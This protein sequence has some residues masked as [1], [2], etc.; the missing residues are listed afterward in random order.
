MFDEEGN[1]VS[2]ELLEE[3]KHLQD[4]ISTQGYQLLIPFKIYDSEEFK[5]RGE[6]I[7]EGSDTAFD[8]LD[9]ALSTLAL[10][11]R[12]NKPFT[13]APAQFDKNGNVVEHNDLDTDITLLPGQKAKNGEE[14]NASQI[15]LTHINPTFDTT[16]FENAIRLI[17]ETALIG[18]M[19]SVSVGM[20]TRTHTDP[21]AAFDRE[22]EKITYHTCNDIQEEIGRASCRERV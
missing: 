17:I 9:E 20:D 11:V 22:R 21:N 1:E 8:M 12:K 18:K 6:S 7:L 13:A 14:R 15:A 19:S 10:A 16:T 3:T 4:E 5:G 2:K